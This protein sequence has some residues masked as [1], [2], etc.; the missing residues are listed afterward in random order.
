MLKLGK[1]MR[2]YWPLNEQGVV[3]NDLMRGKAL[4]M[5]ND[6]QLSQPGMIDGAVQTLRTGYLSSSVPDLGSDKVSGSDGTTW[7]AIDLPVG[8]WEGLTLNKASSGGSVDVYVSNGYVDP[9]DVPGLAVITKLGEGSGAAQGDDFT[10][11]FPFPLA[12]HGGQFRVYLEMKSG[13]T[14]GKHGGGYQNAAYYWSGT[15]WNAAHQIYSIFRGEDAVTWPMINDF[16]VG[17]IVNVD[18]SPGDG[19]VVA[20]SDANE[21]KFRILVKGDKTVEGYSLNTNSASRTVTAPDV[22]QSGFNMI[23][24]SYEKGVISMKIDNA[25][26]EHVFDIG[27]D[28]ETLDPMTIR[29]AKDFDE[30][31]FQGANINQITLSVDHNSLF[32]LTANVIAQKDGAAAITALP[33]SGDPLELVTTPYAGPMLTVAKLDDPNNGEKDIINFIRSLEFTFNNNIGGEDGMR[34]GSRFPF[35]FQGR[36]LDVTARMTLVFRNRDQYADFWGSA[37]APLATIGQERDLLFKWDLNAN[38]TVDLRLFNAY[39]ITPASEVPGRDMLVQTLEWEAVQK[40]PSGV[41][42]VMAAFRYMSMKDHRY[43]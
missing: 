29:V 31:V 34:M 9:T 33:N 35:E 17:V 10:V 26:Y 16:T 7:Q 4:V 19:A 6:S 15:V 28:I 5:F 32:N 30:Q 11:S 24:L 27:G 23:T 42:G 18:A 14:L 39:L 2:H 22:L 20:I 43:F 25:P 37:S 8:I 36:Q 3:H 38:E 21:L 41:A 1:D 40:G 13:M 12:T